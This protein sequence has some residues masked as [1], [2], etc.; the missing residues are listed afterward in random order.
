MSE[1]KRLISIICPVHNEQECIPVFFER[2][3]RAV[4]PLRD[5]YDFELI[6]T[7]NAS[8]D[9]TLDRI[10]ELRERE[11]WVQVLTLSRNFGYQASLMS[12][13]RNAAGDAIVIIDVDCEDPPEMI[14]RFVE[15][16]EKGADLAYGERVDRPEPETLKAARRLFYRLTR[17]MADDDFILDMAEFSLFTR[18]LRDSVL[19]NRSTFPFIRNEIAYAGHRRR[20][21]P[22]TREAR[23][24]G[25]TH[26]NLV[27][28]SKFAIAGA[29]S[30]STFPLRLIAYVGLP[31]AAIDAIAA[32]TSI[33]IGP[34][35]DLAPLILLNVSV[36]LLAA[37]TMAVYLARVHKDTVA[38]PLYVVD[39]RDTHLNRHPVGDR[40]PLS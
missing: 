21:I 8:T 10:L 23:A 17:L 33:A 9:A 36:L 24:R 7:N 2:L 4:A 28:M 11:P 40:D 25:R 1:G 27:R 35:L 15:E 18:A 31:L 12:G 39:R 30:S 32:A 5:R 22:Y 14:P 13:L 20:A 38:R 34:G 37:A 29:L 16:W 19:R 6:F 26:Y 3:R